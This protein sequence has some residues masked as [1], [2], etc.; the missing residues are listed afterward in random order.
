V[1]GLDSPEDVLRHKPTFSAVSVKFAVAAVAPA[2]GVAVQDLTPLKEK[3]LWVTTGALTPGK[4][5][6]LIWNATSAQSSAGRLSANFQCIGFQEEGVVGFMHI[7]TNLMHGAQPTAI[8][9][10]LMAHL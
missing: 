4:K 7:V 10:L 1:Q 3:S 2:P 9:D 5:L 6:P 8:L